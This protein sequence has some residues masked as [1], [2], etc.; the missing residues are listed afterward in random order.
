MK[1]ETPKQKE[2]ENNFSK[3]LTISDNKN[4]NS[5]EINT[6]NSEII[7]ND[8]T[9]KYD[10]KEINSDKDNINKNENS[11]STIKIYPILI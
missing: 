4:D 1:V 10:K 11:K 5:N 7:T 3:I 8:C 6:I 2:K 9:Q